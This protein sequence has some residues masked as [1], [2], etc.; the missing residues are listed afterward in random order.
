MIIFYHVCRFIIFL[1]LISFVHRDDSIGMRARDAILLCMS[2]SKKNKTVAS[3]ITETSNISVLVASGLSGLYSV[4]PNYLDDIAI[5]DW[6]RFTP[7]DV[8]DI[9]GLSTFITSL[10]FS[11]AIAQIAHIS[12]RKQLQ[13]FIY[14]GFLIPVLGP[15]LL[16]SNVEEQVAAMAYTELILRTVTQHGLLYSLLEF[17]LKTEYDGRRLITILTERLST[18]NHQLSLVTLSLFETMIDMNSEDMMLELIFQYLH[19]C[20]HIMFSHRINLL[21][22]DPFCNSYE[23]LLILAPTCCDIDTN[24]PLPSETNTQNNGQQSLCARY[25]SYLYD[26][27]NRIANCHQSCASWSNLYNGQNVFVEKHRATGR[28]SFLY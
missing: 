25:D 3:F 13:E 28:C 12:I 6:Y 5:P 15:A 24:S 10:E 26:A 7:D 16:Q 27:R 11:N 9:K 18:D 1:L 8:N 22:L 19:P 2:M 17:L 4:L 14:R 20:L 23:K 21:M